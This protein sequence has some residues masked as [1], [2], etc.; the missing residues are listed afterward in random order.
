[1]NPLQ[2]FSPADLAALV[3][4]LEE[5]CGGTLHVAVRDL[6]T[7]DTLRHHAEDK[8]KTASVIKLP[9]LVHVALCVHEGSVSW[10]EKLALT[11]AE[12]VDGSGVLTQLTAGLELSLRDV[13]TLM[14]VVSDNTGTNMVIERV[15]AEAINS[16]MR[17]LGL[18]VTTCFRKAY[19]PDTEAGK[20]Y[21]LGVTTPDEMLDLL[22]RLARHEIGD[23]AVSKDILHT[24]AGQFYRD[25]IP[26]LLPAD[27]KYQGKTG[28]V[29]AVRNDVGI[30]ETSDGRQY[31][32][33]LFCQNLPV[34][35]WTADNPGLLALARLTRQLLVE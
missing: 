30:V 3:A 31:A 22:T 33:S 14:T 24:L 18:P 1:M 15:G 32:L 19:S 8:C 16:R 12:K 27:W 10:D 11:D 23:A 6:Q 5:Q 26:R 28:A 25:A 9:I 4:E 29:D 7:G 20:E 2:R 34:V 17:G 13:C 21:G 35:Q